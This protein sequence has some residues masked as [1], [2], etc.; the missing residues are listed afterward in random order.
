MSIEDRRKA[1][2]ELVA[3]GHS[4][5]EIGGILGIHQST[6]VRDANASVD[7]EN[8]NENNDPPEHTDA[9]ASPL[10]AAA[11]IIADD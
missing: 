2:E 6:A 4:T 5:R 10:A 8:N 7:A 1:V 11:A 3:D 9:N